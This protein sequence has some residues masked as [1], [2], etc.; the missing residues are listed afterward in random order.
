MY[1]GV[2]VAFLAIITGIVIAVWL[3]TRSRRSP[4][5]RF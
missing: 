4:N 1:L 2:L 5:R 3:L